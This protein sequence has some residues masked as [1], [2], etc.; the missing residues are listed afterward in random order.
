MDSVRGEHFRTKERNPVNEKCGKIF[1]DRHC[2]KLSLV[3]Q[4]VQKAR[5]R[6]NKE[7]KG[8]EVLQSLGGMEGIGIN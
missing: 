4:M 1:R 3:I 6:Q 8:L 5:W 2:L 7:K